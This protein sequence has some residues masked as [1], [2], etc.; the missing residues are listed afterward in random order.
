MADQLA[1]LKQRPPIDESV[2]PDGL[3]AGV[4]P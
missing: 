2:R 1:A 4:G 3:A